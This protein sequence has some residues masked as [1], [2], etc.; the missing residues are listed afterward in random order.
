[1]TQFPDEQFRH[2]TLSFINDENKAHAAVRQINRASENLSDEPIVISTMAPDHLRSILSESKSFYM[3]FFDAFIAPLET[4]LNQRSTHKTGRAH[5]ADTDAYRNRISA[6]NY[7]L[8]NDD[9]ITVDHYDD[10][11]RI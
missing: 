10:A 5:S 9:G 2:V 7:A 8:A 4:K 1:L 11:E 3:D 6:I